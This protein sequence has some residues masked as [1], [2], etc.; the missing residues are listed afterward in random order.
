MY[1]RDG[2]ICAD[3]IDATGAPAVADRWTGR[4]SMPA[5]G[6]L[7]TDGRE[8]QAQAELCGNARG[9]HQEHAAMTDGDNQEPPRRRLHD[10]V[11]VQM[12]IV[13]DEDPEALTI[14]ELKELK[15]LASMSKTARFIMTLAIG[16]VSAIGIPVL[17]D[18]F[19][20]H[21]K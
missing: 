17:L 19:K 2:A 18:F 13:N 10:R 6:C 5:D 4:A 20:N 1:E 3:E 21:W 11:T 9:H 15:R 7:R 16:I 12:K 8:R 14:S